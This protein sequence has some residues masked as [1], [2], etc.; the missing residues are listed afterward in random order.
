MGK[1]CEMCFFLKTSITYVCNNQS[2][3]SKKKKKVTLG[4]SYN[5]INMLCRL[6]FADN[7]NLKKKSF[8]LKTK[9]TEKT[10]IEHYFVIF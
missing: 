7:T 6:K 1:S 3:S 10:H 5:I 8:S 2:N 9:M 4:P